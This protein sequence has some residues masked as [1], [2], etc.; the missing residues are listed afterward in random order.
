VKTVRFP[1][2]D[3][4][5]LAA[6]GAWRAFYSR[7]IM[8]V[9]MEAPDG[10]PANF[11]AR[12]LDLPGLLVAFITATPSKII[13]SPAQAKDGNS[14]YLLVVPTSGAVVIDVQGREMRL[15]RGGGALLAAGIASVCSI[16]TVSTLLT[17][18]LPAACIDP[19]L[20]SLEDVSASLIAATA[21]GLQLLVAYLTSIAD[22]IADGRALTDPVVRQLVASHL[23]NLA[24]VAIHAGQGARPVAK[25]AHAARL[26]AL[27]EIVLHML[28]QPDLSAETVAA[29][30][31]VSSRYIRRQFEV[32]GESFGAF[33]LAQRLI[34]IHALLSDP[35]HAARAI[36]TIAAE[37]G[38]ADASYFNR[39]FRNRYRTTPS[40]VRRA[41]LATLDMGLAQPAP[42]DEPAR[43]ERAS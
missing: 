8:A 43:D 24:V 31:G 7:M 17:L 35:R 36:G 5:P 39:A 38:F 28:P 27:K 11:M 1:A 2:D 15:E 42:R 41:A 13:R 26:L 10:A 6:L 9:T 23:T 34:R 12:I 30:Q 20:A 37:C 3:A 4:S 29:Q 19:A 25:G 40:E 16:T 18:V 33:V 14:D 21:D 22:D 32:N